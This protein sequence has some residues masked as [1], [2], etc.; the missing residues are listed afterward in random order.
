MTKWRSQ[1]FTSE[2]ASRKIS[3]VVYEK[4]NLQTFDNV[5]FAHKLFEWLGNCEPVWDV[6]NS[7]SFFFLE[8]WINLYM[9]AYWMKFPFFSHFLTFSRLDGRKVLTEQEKR[10]VATG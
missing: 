5:N 2:A 3:G 9:Y 1:N 4:Y 10:V 8:M 6:K 7:W